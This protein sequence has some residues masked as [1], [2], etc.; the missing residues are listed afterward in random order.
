MRG[1]ASLSG[2]SFVIVVVAACGSPPA[3][4][5]PAKPPQRGFFDVRAV[6]DVALHHRAGTRLRPR[7][8]VTQSGARELMGIRDTQLG[9]DC[10]FRPTPSGLRCVPD[11][12]ALSTLTDTTQSFRDE[13]C[14]VQ[15]A[16]GFGDGASR[17][18][19]M[20][21]ATTLD[22]PDAPLRVFEAQSPSRVTEL[23]GRTSSGE[24]RRSMKVGGGIDTATRGRELTQELVGAKLV[25]VGFGGEG[26]RAAYF[27]AVDGAV[28]FSHWID[29]KLD[30]ACSITTA[31]DG[32]ARC[33]PDGLFLSTTF[34]DAA[35]ST[36]GASTA[37]TAPRFMV[38]ADARCTA[39]AH[40]FHT[41]SS[42][43]GD[44]FIGDGVACFRQTLSS[45]GKKT[46]SPGK[47]IDPAFLVA[48][49]RVEDD[50]HAKRLRR[51]LVTTGELRDTAPGHEPWRDTELGV[52]CS[53]WPGTDGVMRCLPSRDSSAE[54]EAF[55]DEECARPAD[56]V[57]AAPATRSGCSRE[58]PPPPRYARSVINDESLAV[59]GRGRARVHRLD[60]WP[61]EKPIYV[62]QPQR[63]CVRM[64]IDEVASLR[65]EG[66]EVPAA[67]FEAGTESIE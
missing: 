21:D 59:E 15:V 13:A 44:Y 38:K 20:R 30:A 31:A 48:T 5:A 60:P 3:P 19:V 12:D 47:E 25:V 67:A 18:V 33:V 41:G 65:V 45:R 32:E 42:S 62:K 37:C 17:F 64:P 27:E 63:G 43:P 28:T 10:K 7:W 35:C 4:V 23:F 8:R 53:F 2:L 40:A 55:R 1:A 57:Y 29:P 56:P 9:V 52:E 26:L 16:I 36:P 24:C 54:V 11:P 39:R 58:A 66:A 6:R 49:P 50:G 14:A 51:I 22:C 46:Y 61:I 34:A